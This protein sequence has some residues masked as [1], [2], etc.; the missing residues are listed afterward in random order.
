MSEEE[1][2]LRYEDVV[3]NNK[4]LERIAEKKNHK[5]INLEKQIINDRIFYMNLINKLNTKIIGLQD[6]IIEFQLSAMEATE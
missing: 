1:N 2:I 3:E 6:Q 4:T 5:I